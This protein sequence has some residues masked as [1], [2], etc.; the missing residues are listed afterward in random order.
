[1]TVVEGRSREERACRR[2]ERDEEIRLFSP[3]LVDIHPD[4]ARSVWDLSDQLG[5]PLGWHYVLDLVW[6]VSQ[7]TDLRGQ[8]IPDAGAGWGLLQWFL[9]EQGATV[10]SVDRRDRRQAESHF[11]RRYRLSNSSGSGLEPLTARDAWAEAR[12]RGRAIAVRKLMRRFAG[13]LA[14][15]V[16]P[17]ARGR[18]VL[19]DADLESLP[20]VATG[21]IDCVVSISALEHNPTSKIPVIVSE[22]TRVLKPGGRLLAT[23]A[24]S[25]DEDF[26]H[27]PPQGWCLTERSLCEAFLL[28]SDASSN[29]ADYD[30]VFKKLKTSEVLR[31][32]LSAFYSTSG[33]NG[34]PW[35]TW[36]PKYQPVGIRKRKPER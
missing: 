10:V 7:L 3:D 12:I 18:V 25:R 28:G 35:G 1:M 32:R 15:A 31:E 34:M 9:A 13:L 20:E 26:F 5:I 17:T 21:S 16:G 14:A 19:H 22:L 2:V 27:E 36:D 8:R 33:S 23:V 29:F 6:V 30:D 11:R 24:A 4:L